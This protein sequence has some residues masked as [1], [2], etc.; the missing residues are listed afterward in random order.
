MEK[1]KLIFFFLAV[2]NVCLL[3]DNQWLELTFRNKKI[4]LLS[5][6]ILLEFAKVLA[7]EPL[8]NPSLLQFFITEES[9]ETLLS[10][11]FSS[12]PLTLCLS[13]A[14]SSAPSLCISGKAARCFSNRCL[15][16]SVAFASSPC[17]LHARAHPCLFPG[18]RP[19]SYRW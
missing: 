14:G 2:D 4:S 3:Q 16:P 11:P 13:A 17:T 1:V 7:S 5:L 15:L 18:R 9:W 8:Q 10:S 6:K 19:L 12:L